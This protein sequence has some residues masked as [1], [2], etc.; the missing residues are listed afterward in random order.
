M[1][2]DGG[3]GDWQHLLTG[4]ERARMLDD[5]GRVSL[6]VGRGLFPERAWDD[7]DIAA[8]SLAERKSPVE[9]LGFIERLLPDLTRAVHRIGE[10]PLTRA[11]GQPHTVTPPQ[12][13]RR[14][15][16]SALLAAVRRGHAGRFVEERRTVWTADTPEN[17]AVKAFLSALRLDAAAIGGIAQAAG[18]AEIAGA[19]R[20]AAG[21]LRGLEAMPLWAS[22]ADDAA[23]WRAPPTHRAL[24]DALYARLSEAMR[25]YRQGFQFDWAHP[26]FS[27]P[28]REAWRLYEV[29]GLFQALE[30]LLTLGYAPASEPGA[31][32][33]LFAVHQDRLT[34]AVVKGTE[35]R[36]GL[37]GPDGHSLS[38]FY[39]RAYPQETRSLS[40]TMQPDIALERP[41]GTTWVLDP[42]FKAYALP[43]SEGDDMDQMHAYRDAIIDTQGRKAVARAW[44]LFCGPAEG[45]S[46]PM[47]AYGTPAASVVGAL[48]LHP[49]D[50]EGF[51]RLCHLL[52]GW[53]NRSA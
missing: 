45:S 22:V 31:A 34:F 38:V 47:I 13:A 33:A 51:E 2:A 20:A 9:R 4:G 49:G 23:A 52:A 53:V 14:V 1:T 5:I 27:L 21:R 35:S 11:V 43:G 3:A 39:N 19:V 41:D 42:K 10:T 28:A 6:A 26:L 50:P 48:H 18:E 40:R 30:A 44:C 46:R 7:L 17:R 29:W 24:S 37:T 36:V 16:A 25:R 8:R 15:E 32:N 12:R